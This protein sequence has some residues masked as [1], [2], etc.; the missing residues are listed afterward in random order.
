M[1]I[2]NDYII[3]LGIETLILTMTL[4]AF[5]ISEHHVRLL[6]KQHVLWLSYCP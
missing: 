3:R 6:R 1:M 4:N 5:L 2:N